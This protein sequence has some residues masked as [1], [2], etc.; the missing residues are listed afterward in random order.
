[1]KLLVVTNAPIIYKNGKAFAYGPYVNE[2]IVWAK[3]AEVVFCCPVWESDNGLLI[4]EIPF[5]ISGHYKLRDNNLKSFKEIVKTFFFSFVNM[6]ILL[7]AM[8]NADHIHL[9]C[10]GNIGLLGCIMQVFFPN[11]KKTAKYAGN[12]DPES[13]QPLSYRLQK[14]ILNNSFLTRNIQVLV[15]GSW[16]NQS[17]NIKSFFTATYSEIEK[18]T[19][20]KDNIDEVA[21][22]IFVGSLVVGKNPLYAI[23]LVQMLNESGIKANLDLYG[24]GTEKNNLEIYIKENKLEEFVFLRGNQ[25]KDVVS[26]AYQKSHFVLLASK[27]EGWPK[28]IAEGMFWGCVPVATKISCVP[29]MLDEGNRG[30]FLEMSLEKDSTQLKAIIANKDI[31]A[32]KSKLAEDWSRTYTTD[33]FE[34]EIK[35]LL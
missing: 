7:K 19:V 31:F 15:Y 20:I 8:Y 25:E 10:P 21:K 4:S 14:W 18:Q 22:F 3:Y 26:K 12:W 9:R 5:K 24:N 16:K 13:K 33:F 34:K 2:L 28:A 23:K 35:N 1:M 32:K 11:K 29:F 30:V 27:S 17:K 6:F